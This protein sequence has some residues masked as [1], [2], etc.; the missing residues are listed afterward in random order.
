MFKIR[1]T[2]LSVLFSNLGFAQLEVHTI[3]SATK[4]PHPFVNVMVEKSN[5]IVAM[6]YTDADGYVEIYP[7]DT[8]RYNISAVGNFG[9]YDDSLKGILIESNQI[10]KIEMRLRARPDTDRIIIIQHNHPQREQK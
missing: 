7:I 4:M 6:I 1:F 10:T 3:D 9:Y 8:G 2:I 5:K